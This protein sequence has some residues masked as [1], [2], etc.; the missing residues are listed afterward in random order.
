MLD[1]PNVQARWPLGKDDI[2]QYLAFLEAGGIM[3]ELPGAIPAVVSDPD[4][5]PIVQ[6]AITG[7]ADV[8]CTR[9]EAFYVEQVRLLCTAHNF[10]ILDDVALMKELRRSASA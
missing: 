3:V 10:R 1:Y 8:L 7:R 9:D 6:T 2:D 5:D 4:D